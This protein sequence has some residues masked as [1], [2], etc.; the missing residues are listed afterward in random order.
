[1]LVHDFFNGYM[2]VSLPSCALREE[3]PFAMASTV[4]SNTSKQIP[5]AHGTT[6]HQQ[7]SSFGN[8]ENDPSLMNRQTT[9]P[10]RVVN[11]TSA[12]SEVPKKISTQDRLPITQK[13]CSTGTHPQIPVRT[14]DG[15]QQLSCSGGLVQPVPRRQPLTVVSSNAL[16]ASSALASN[17]QCK[18]STRHSENGYSIPLQT[19]LSAPAVPAQQPRPSSSTFRSQALADRTDGRTTTASIR[20]SQSQKFEI[21]NDEREY[22]R[23]S[24]GPLSSVAA[25]A[26]AVARGASNAMPNGSND[27]LLQKYSDDVASA[28]DDYASD[29]DPIEAEIRE[30]RNS[31]IGMPQK[32]YASRGSESAVNPSSKAPRCDCK[33]YDMGEE[34]EQLQLDLDEVHLDEN[35]SR[36]SKIVGRAASSRSNLPVSSSHL[37]QSRVPQAQ[38]AWT[39]EYIKPASAQLP[40]LSTPPDQ[41]TSKQ[42]NMGTLET[43]HEI[44]SQSFASK[45]F[46]SDAGGF[47]GLN[48]GGTA[49][50]MTRILP[51]LQLQNLVAQVWVVRYVDY[52][53]KYGLG[54]LLNTGSA[55]VY[56]N[57]STKIV[58]SADGSMFLYVERRR[59]SPSNGGSN[60]LATASIL[61]EHVSQ[62]YSI[63]AYPSELQKKVTLL[64]HFRTY[65]LDQQRA[66]GSA[67]DGGCGGID[68]LTASI[69]ACTTDDKNNLGSQN[70]LQ[71]S[72]LQH[73]EESMPFLK[74]WVR[75]RHA[76]LFRLSNRTV[77][78][79]FFDRS[80]VLLSSEAKIVTYVNKIGDRSEHTLEE[81]LQT[82]RADIAKRLKYTKDI[83]YR[84]INM[85]MK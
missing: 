72:G 16:A 15:E 56:F 27:F 84:L 23:T 79:V 47:D 55:G 65:L 24:T 83:L 51:R 14:L 45:Q 31:T 44:L 71:V 43:M 35:K 4:S 54:F 34:L 36:S 38:E 53:S 18:T 26:I 61:S 69:N 33:E 74:K 81:V 60:A 41:I 17:A 70:D 7:S 67:G 63:T 9:M 25:T 73:S 22:E 80:E 48:D 19:K 46:D 5:M 20:T 76:I 10:D 32:S 59:R 77:Q 1:M 28:Q 50:T 29:I 42:A 62:S 75:T 82:G 8:N 21:F 58:L 11:A 2:P 40:G 64:R 39:S 6:K 3:P 12:F 52:T 78:I 68:G 13:P 57:D 30:Q 37:V 66:N 85:Q 49:T